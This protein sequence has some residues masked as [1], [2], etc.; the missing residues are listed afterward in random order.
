MKVLDKKSF[1]LPYVDSDTYRTL[2]RLGLRYDRQMRTYSAEDLEEDKAESV[3]ELLAKILKEDVN[4]NQNTSLAKPEQA[5]QKCLGCG[6]NFSCN[7]CRYFELCETKN[8]SSSCIC[9]TCLEKGKPS[10]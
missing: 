1:K 8:V 10:A 7:E 3:L 4:F 9:G 5:V 6:K 2:M